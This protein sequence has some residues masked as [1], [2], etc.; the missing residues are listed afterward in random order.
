MVVN[1]FGL[2]FFGLCYVGMY[3]ATSKVYY[4][5]VTKL[6]IKDIYIDESF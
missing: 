2:L 6:N 5:I 1:C 4:L 3:K